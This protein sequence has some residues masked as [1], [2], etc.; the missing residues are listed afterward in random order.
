M[1]K[2]VRR[3]AAS[4]ELWSNLN[5]RELAMPKLRCWSCGRGPYLHPGILIILG[6]ATLIEY[7][8]GRVVHEQVQW[9]S[10]L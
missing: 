10:S 3:L 7:Q 4:E 6:L 8:R 2:W 9:A 5:N 1:K